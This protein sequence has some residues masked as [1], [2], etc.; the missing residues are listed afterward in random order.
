MP[1]WLY[2]GDMK[3]CTKCREYLPLDSFHASRRRKDGRR[4]ICKLCANE[5]AKQWY[6]AN[7]EQAAAAARRRRGYQ[8]RWRRTMRY[9]LPE[10]RFE[11]MLAEQDGAC[12]LC[13]APFDPDAPRR[14]AHIDHDHRCC[15][16]QTSC[17]QCVR[18]LLCYRCNVSI[19]AAES[20]AAWL[21]RVAKYLGYS[22]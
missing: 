21:G 10:G 18:G 5:A 13:R 17:G 6:E 9:G 16:G 22:I 20:D 11:E 14:Q 1:S 7:K 15:P 2:T 3:T 4:G 8:E 19:P 12:A